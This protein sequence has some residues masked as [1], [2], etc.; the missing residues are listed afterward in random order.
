MARQSFIERFA[1]NR[2]R[3]KTI[4][5]PFA[6][7]EG[8]TRPRVRLRVLGT[9][10]LE[11]AYLATRDYFAAG[12]KK[13]APNDA[14]FVVREHV[15]LVWIAF[16]DDDGQPLAPSASDL[17]KE[18]SELLEPLYAQ[19]STFQS[20]VAGAELKQED[21]D[22]L[23]DELKKNTQGDLL[24]ALP[25]TWLRSLLR[26]SVSQLRISMQASEPG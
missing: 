13:V 24:A 3:S 4:H 25:S 2:P 15:E 6:V 14:A 26:T 9:H 11:A 20:E 16:A 10:E 17:A 18:P 12:K 1:L 22:G 7:N 8:E 21:L 23:I 19:W 5:W